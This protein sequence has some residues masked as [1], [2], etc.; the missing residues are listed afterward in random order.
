[1]TEPRVLH[2]AD[3]DAPTRRDLRALLDL[4]F[5]GEFPDEDW[6]HCLG[7]LHALLYSGDTLIGHAAVVQ[8]QLLHQGRTLRTGYVEGVAV[9]PAHQRR[10][11]GGTLMAPLERIIR[12]GYQLGAL[13]AAQDAQPLYRRRGWLP[14]LGTTAALTPEGILP[15]PEETEAVH[16][17]PVDAA[18]DRTGLLT[19]DWRD[20][21]L[22]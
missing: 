1:M 21:D 17:L 18:L 2:T 15:T 9:H 3:L 13:G 10:G 5:D 4:A 19:C 11:H 22:W 20:G 8:R 12:H 6:E 16:V 14:W 7:G